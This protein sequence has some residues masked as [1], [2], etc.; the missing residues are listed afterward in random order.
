MAVTKYSLEPLL[1]REEEV[2]PERSTL[3]KRFDENAMSSKSVS[4]FKFFMS[5]NYGNKKSLLRRIKNPIF[6]T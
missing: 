6:F 5:V 3:A 1:D 4:I 2:S